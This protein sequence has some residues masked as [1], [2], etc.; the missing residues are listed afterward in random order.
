MKN[1]QEKKG[2]LEISRKDTAAKKKNPAPDMEK[3]GGLHPK[4]GLLGDPREKEK[5]VSHPKEK[6]AKVFHNNG[7]G[8]RKRD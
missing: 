6:N 5:G 1:I 8:G 3:T 2:T 4:K 7:R